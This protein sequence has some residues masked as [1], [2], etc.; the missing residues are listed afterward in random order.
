MIPLV[1]RSVKTTR[2]GEEL[3]RVADA[4]R[5]CS[6][7]IGGPVLRGCAAPRFLRLS[8]TLSDSYQKNC[9]VA[10]EPRLLTFTRLLVGVNSGDEHCP[11]VDQ[12]DEPGFRG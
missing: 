1:T 4:P 11:R 12:C 6:S 7:A 10:H 3:H 2:R 8:A 5:G 9:R